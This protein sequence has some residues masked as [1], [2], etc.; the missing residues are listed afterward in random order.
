MFYYH[1]ENILKFDN[2]IHTEQKAS[3]F[4]KNL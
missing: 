4:E 3:Q 1:G 2:S